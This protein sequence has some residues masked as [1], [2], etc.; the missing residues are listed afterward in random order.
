[1][2]TVDSG[3]KRSKA[4]RSSHHKHNT[5]TFINDTTLEYNTNGHSHAN[6]SKTTV[7]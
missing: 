3:L 1:M 5:T 2:K 4:T 6:L 7:F